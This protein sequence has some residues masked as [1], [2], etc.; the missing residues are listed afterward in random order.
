MF[1]SVPV[2]WFGVKLGD[3]FIAGFR[4][5]SHLPATFCTLRLK[6]LVPVIAF[7]FVEIM[8]II[9]GADSFVKSKFSIIIH[10]KSESLCLLSVKRL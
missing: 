3:V 10:K 4:C 5:A 9:S 7:V 6:L 8:P 1:L 2:S